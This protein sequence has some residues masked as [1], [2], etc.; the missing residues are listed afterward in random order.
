MKYSLVS[1]LFVLAIG[2][3][4][5]LVISTNALAVDI[6][7]GYI[8]VG[9]FTGVF[10]SDGVTL[11][12]DGDIVQC[13]YAGPDGKIDPPNADGTAG[14]DDVLLELAFEPGKYSTVIGASFPC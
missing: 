2:F 4:C 3:V 14:G 13:L 10:K 8:A 5:L 6:T 9:C 7:P 12:K 11:L 1:R